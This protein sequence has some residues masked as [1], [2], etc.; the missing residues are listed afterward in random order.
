MHSRIAAS[1]VLIL[2]VAVLAFMAGQWSVKRSILGP[3]AAITIVEADLEFDALLDTGAVVSSINAHEIEVVGG[4]SRPSR[5][6]V[7]KIIR[8]VLVNAA[9]RRQPVSAEI[10]Q[11]RGIRMADCREVRYHVYL[12][13]A[14]AGRRHRVLMNLNDRSRS[15]AKLLLGRNWLYHGYAV[16]PVTEPEI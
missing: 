6:D 7:G 13:V 2:A 4:G 11:V 8:F 9:G 1:A 16:A 14:H 5:R 3:R 15:K 12:T 10:A